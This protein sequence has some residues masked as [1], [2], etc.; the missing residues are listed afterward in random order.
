MAVSF[1]VILFLIGSWANSYAE[2]ARHVWKARPEN[3]GRLYTEGL[4]RYTRHPNYFGDLLSFSGLCLI[5]GAWITALIPLIMLAGFVFVNVPMPD[6]HLRDH[7][8]AAFDEYARRTRK[9]IPFLY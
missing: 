4:F 6:S 3:H 5:S 8:G 2:Y 1:G 7:Y 9:L